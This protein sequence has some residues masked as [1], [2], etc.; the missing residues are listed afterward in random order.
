MD[1]VYNSVNTG[2]MRRRNALYSSNIMLNEQG[3]IHLDAMT[4]MKINF[5]CQQKTMWVREKA[6]ELDSSRFKH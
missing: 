5:M 2:S 4:K 1:Q 3:W 6:K